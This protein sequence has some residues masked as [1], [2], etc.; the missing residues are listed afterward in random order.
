MFLDIMNN[1]KG[2]E[3]ATEEDAMEMMTH[4]IPTTK[5][6]SCLNICVMEKTGIVSSL[7][8]AIGIFE[9]N[10]KLFL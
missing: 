5:T 1:C 7:D 4:S 3:G 8:A 2:A 10:R 6:G 9:H